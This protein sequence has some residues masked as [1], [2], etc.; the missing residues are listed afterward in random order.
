MNRNR[1]AMVVFSSYPQDPRVRREAEA[2]EEKGYLLDIFCLKYNDQAKKEKYGNI[3]VY[4]SSVSRSR[5]WKIM[6]IL[7]YSLFILSMFFFVTIKSIAKRYKIIHVHNMPDIVIFIGLLPKIFGAKLILDLHDPTPE[8]YMSKYNIDKNHKMIRLLIALE[9]FSI[10]LA[11]HVITPNKAFKDLFV[12]RG[13]KD[14]KI[15]I[16][17]NS[18]NEKIFNRTTFSKKTNT[19][20][21]FSIIYHGSIVER[22]GLY[23]A[24]IAVKK[25]R[26]KIPDMTFNIY[27]VGDYSKRFNEDINKLNLNDIVFFHGV[28]AQELLVEKILS[29]DLGIIPN[30]RDPFTEINLPTRIFEYLCLGKPV[31]APHTRGISDYFDDDSLIYFDSGNADDLAK[32]I[33]KVY[34]KP[35]KFKKIIKNGIEVYKKYKWA[36]QKKKL[37]SIYSNLLNKKNK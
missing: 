17:M 36:E 37:I 16:V 13:C 11:N 15:D 12:S 28:L 29:S 19:K 8:V 26:G 31:I 14:K 34:S 22:H 9:K 32:V 30:R 23:D 25:L 21:K 24:L 4:R 7:E 10:K 3:T 33:F 27:G 2:L 1:I 18:P 20:N 35:E 5:S 6:Y